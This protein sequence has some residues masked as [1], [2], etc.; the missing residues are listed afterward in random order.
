MLEKSTQELIYHTPK[1]FQGINIYFTKMKKPPDGF[2]THLFFVSSI[3]LIFGGLFLH[4][5]SKLLK[6]YIK[7]LRVPTTDFVRKKMQN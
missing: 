3:I 6:V 4:S 1:T 7:W 2:C 5:L